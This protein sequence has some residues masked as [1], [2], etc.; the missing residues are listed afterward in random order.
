MAEAYYSKASTI[1]TSKPPP[2]FTFLLLLV[3]CILGFYTLHYPH[4]APSLSNPE[5]AL[6]YRQIFLSSATNSTLASYLRALTQHPH[7]AGTKASLDTVNYVLSKFMDLDLETRTANYTALLSYP[8]HSSLSA[9]FSNGTVVDIPLAELAESANVV[10]PY[11]AYSPSGSAHAKVAFVNHGTD[12]DYRALGKLGVNVSGC[13]V[14]ARKGGLPRGVMVRKAETQ[15]ASAVLL[16]TE[17]DMF[18]KGFER[19][20]VMSGVGDPLSPGWAGVDGG[21]RLHSEDSEVLKRF[22]RIPSMPLS[23]EAAEFILGSLGGAQSPPGWPTGV[24][25]GP[26]PTMLNFTYQVGAMCISVLA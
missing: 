3:L 7:I 22:P 20:T 10:R 25:V 8:V 24:G 2:V 21:E 15:G 14:I 17:G 16:Y 6:R 19:G 9:H 26:G 12:E 13:V 11:H 5:A 4:P 1:F 18:K 23:A